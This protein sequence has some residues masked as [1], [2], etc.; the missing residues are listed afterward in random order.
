MRSHD[1]EILSSYLD[2]QLG[3]SETTRLEERI[4]SDSELRELL[5]DLRFARAALKQVP[6]RRVPRNFVLKP[7]M[8]ALKGPVPRSVPALRFAS[9]LAAL[10]LL[11]T[12][13]INSL[14][15]RARATPAAAPVPAYGMGGGAGAPSPEALL[16]SNAAQ[17]PAEGRDTTGT[18]SPQQTMA[19]TAQSGAE[20]LPK[21]AP[22]A[23]PRNPPRPTPPIV[24]PP[25]WQILLGALAVLSAGLAW[26][27][28][29]A[30]RRNFTSRYLEK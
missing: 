7:S 18:T 3:P 29:R 24:V 28:Y 16:Q 20:A 5:A 27:A 8:A 12:F 23:V 13:A 26:Y 17:A 10:L 6:R 15:T 30:S 14:A 4:H 1:A 2:G 25:I 22:L 19:P 9:V 21:E 11:A